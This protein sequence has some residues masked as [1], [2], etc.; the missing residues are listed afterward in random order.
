MLCGLSPRVRGNQSLGRVR[1]PVV[2][3]IPACAGEPPYLG[4]RRRHIGVY[5]RVCGGTVSAVVA[6]YPAGGLSPRVRGNHRIWDR[7]GDILGSIPACAGEP[8]KHGTPSLTSAVYPR[9][10]GGTASLLAP[11]ASVIGLSPR[12]RGNRWDVSSSCVGPGSIPACAG[13]PPSGFQPAR[14]TRV[15]PRVCGGTTVTFSGLGVFYGL[16]PRVRGNPRSEW[17]WQ[18]FVG[19]IP[20]CAGEPSVECTVPHMLRVYPR[21]CGGT[22]QHDFLSQPLLGLSPRVRGNR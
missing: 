2:G 8:G 10:C 6:R 9:V 20:A 18:R 1:F 14:S 15:Y 12:V 17:C 16:S 13:E 4:S 11:V 7:E 19:S 22:G 5:P 3:S 21:V